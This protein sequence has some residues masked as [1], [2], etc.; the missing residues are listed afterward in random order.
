MSTTPSPVPRS[1]LAP[2]P[3]GLLHP[4]N[5]VNFILTWAIT[6]A[7]AGNLLLRIDDLDQERC[8]D[9]Y[10]EDVFRTIDWLGIDYDEGPTTVTDLHQ[11]WSQQLR[12]DHYAQGLQKLREGEYLFAC[13]CSRRTLRAT[14]TDGRY[15]GTCFTRNLPFDQEQTAWRV[16]PLRETKLLPFRQ[17]FGP[18]EQLDLSTLDAFVV[19][20]KN[21][22]TAY[23]LSSIIDDELFGINTIVRGLDLLPSTHYQLYLASLLHNTTFLNTRFYHHGMLLNEQG[24]KLA[25]SKKATSLQSW[26][27][28]GRGPEE[29]YQQ[30]ARMLGLPT[31]CPDGKTLVQLLQ[32]QQL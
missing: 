19:K 23:Q 32:S 8:R 14:S 1:R 4:G 3:S 24:E 22:F 28:E 16:R 29:L 13:D 10:V 27:Q 5:G 9:R 20:Q 2:T 7:N 12:R 26:R 6:R 21:D 17:I 30:A 11:N 25:K 31:S 18:D 15:P